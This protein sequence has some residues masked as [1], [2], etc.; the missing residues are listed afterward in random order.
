MLLTPG[1]R[2]EIA[3]FTQAAEVAGSVAQMVWTGAY[4]RPSAISEPLK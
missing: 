1:S 3:V 2:L 4:P